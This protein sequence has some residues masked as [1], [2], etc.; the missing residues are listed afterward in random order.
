VKEGSALSLGNMNLNFLETRMLHWPDSMFTYLAEEKILFSQDAFGMHLASAE[1]YADGIAPEILECEGEK[2]FA[3]ILLPF[4]PLVLKLLDKVAGL[5]LPIEI[6]APDHGPIWRKD[7]GKILGYY[8]KWAEQK[9]TKKVLIFYD[10]MWGSTDIMARA[11][12]DGASESGA[13]VSVLKL[14]AA[15]RSD[16][17]KEILDAGA[18]IVGSPTLNNGI[19]PTLADTLTY[20]KG[21][22]PKNKIGAAFG[23]YGWSGESVGIIETMLKEMGIEIFAESVKA[24]FV[25]TKEVLDKCREL[26]RNI[27]I[28][29]SE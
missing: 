29:L 27:G 12:A 16:I 21:L 18:V 20:I 3:N 22:K 14:R 26:G 13:K 9:P 25:P 17:A 28:R 15:T 1:R 8:K 2:Y 5:N 11:I 7:L 4:S 19:F 10:T 6:I 24:K 23:S